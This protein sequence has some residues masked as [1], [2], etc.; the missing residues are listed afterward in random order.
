MSTFFIS[1]LH[2]GHEKAIIF[3]N[4]P[5]K[6]IEDM[7]RALVSNWNGVVSADDTVYILGDV[8]WYAAEKTAKILHSLKGTKILIKGN[9]DYFVRDELCKSEFKEI[10]DYKEI[11]LNGDDI[12]LSHFPI[13][14]FNKQMY[15]AIHLYG[16]VHTAPD[17][18][19]LLSYIED[20]KE[21]HPCNMYNVGCMIDY[22]NY[23]PKTLEQIIKRK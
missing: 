21:V 12:I 13:M 9:H 3:D 1:D 5:F 23:T 7:D 11:K 20:I 15:N 17:Y 8:S 18:Y 14:M 22:M 19:R 16:H 4:R 2:F 10:R 6:N